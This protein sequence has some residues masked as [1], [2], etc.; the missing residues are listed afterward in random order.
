MVRPQ[1]HKS[2][3]D[4]ITDDNK[5]YTLILQN[6]NVNTFDFVIETLVEVCNHSY[7]QAE[8]CALITHFKGK[9]EIKTGSYDYLSKLKRTI[10]NKGLK[11]TIY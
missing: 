2:P 9:C 5:R 6:D 4:K 10:N 7:E 1:K 11:S 8:Q 3:K